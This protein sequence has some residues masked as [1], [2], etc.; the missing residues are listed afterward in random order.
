MENIEVICS[1]MSMFFGLVLICFAVFAIGFLI[2]YKYEEKRIFKKTVRT[3]GYDI[4][5]SEEEKRAKREWKNFLKYDG[6]AIGENMR[7]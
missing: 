6:S 4:Q 7:L 2:G 3:D 1:V 5:E